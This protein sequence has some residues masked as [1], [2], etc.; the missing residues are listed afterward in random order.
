M[1]TL[2]TLLF[3][4]GFPSTSR[5]WRHQVTY[6]ASRGY[7]LLV[8]DLL[9]F[10]GSALPVDPESYRPSDICRDILDILDAENVQ[11]VV[12]IGHDL[13]VISD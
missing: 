3:L 4:H 2:P 9:G 10:G 6:F 11:Q 8:P 13:Y 5:L 12:V 1:E 7:P